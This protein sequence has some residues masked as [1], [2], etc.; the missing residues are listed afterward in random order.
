M[1]KKRGNY[2]G[3]LKYFPT[4]V[5]AYPYTNVIIVLTYT[6]CKD[7]F[8]NISLVKHGLTL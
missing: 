6:R 5:S 8:R 7:Q 1:L 4:S 3:R 2:I